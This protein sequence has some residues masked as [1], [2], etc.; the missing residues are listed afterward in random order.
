M[1]ELGAPVATTDGADGELGVD[2]GTTDGTG[3]LLGTLGTETKV[4]VFI[5]DGDDATKARALTS[6]GL[7]LNGHDLHD[8]VDELA[9]FVTLAGS[10]AEEVIDNLVLLDW[11]GVQKDLFERLNLVGSDETT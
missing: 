5:T 7:L 2:N 10:T 6:T 4:T 8:L 9:R 11:D 1:A 3:D